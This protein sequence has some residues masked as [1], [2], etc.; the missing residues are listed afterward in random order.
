MIA[1]PAGRII[2]QP[3]GRITALACWCG[4]F[5]VA[6]AQDSPEAEAAREARLKAMYGIAQRFKVQAGEGADRKPVPLMEA[7]ILR[8]NDPAREFH[9][10]TL[11]AW[12]ESGRP[13]C[14]LAIEQ[15][16]DRSWF[17]MISLAA[18][19]QPFTA[20]AEALRWAPRSGGIDL[21]PFPDALPAAD[22]APRRLVQMK[23]LLGQLAAYEVG[24][25]DNRYELRLMPRPLHRYEDE[26]AE[27]VDGAIF[28]FAYGTNP[29]LLAVIEA[30]GPAT[31][32]KW[33][34]GFARCGTAEP[35]VLLKDKE[36]FTLPYAKGTGPE[37]P[38]W[39]Y[40]YT[41]KKAE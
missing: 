41:F 22:K 37:D 30:R 4:L 38:Y 7:P 31:S 21:K 35:H 11:W 26:K 28:A 34:V 32:A 40:S 14:L 8:F 9:D 2:A 20:E 33:H 12:G 25:T 27:L 3:A 24:R 6:T 19:S 13:L 1:Q 15:Y 39:N 5:A 17:E 10:A 29:E 23:E 16:G 18:A 36:I